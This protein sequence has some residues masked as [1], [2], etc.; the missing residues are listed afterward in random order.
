MKPFK[1]A[2]KGNV[3]L[4]WETLYESFELVE[5]RTKESLKG[6]GSLSEQVAA[7]LQHLQRHAVRP[8]IQVNGHSLGAAIATFYVAD[9]SFP[10]P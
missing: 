10:Q 1:V 3:A 6:R 7:H 9:T 2:G 8:S 4:G 5:H